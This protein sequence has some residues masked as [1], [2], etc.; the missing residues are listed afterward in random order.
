MSSMRFGCPVGRP[1]AFNEE[2]ALGKALEVFWCKGYDGASLT[3]LTEAMGINKPSLYAT[4]GNKEQLFLKALDLYEHR[5]CAYFSP[6]LEEP[7]ARQV[8]EHMLLGAA[9]SFTTKTG[10]RG[11]VVVQSALACSEAS[12]SVK[13]ALVARRREGENLLR[14]RL[15]RAKEE[16]DLPADADPALL[17]RYIGTV[18]QGMAVQAVNGATAEQLKEVALMTLNTWPTK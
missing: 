8:V 2:E 13:E 4:F 18:A 14:E 3:D 15:E 6:A 16:G 12:A 17:A 1:R 10:P 11:C 5:P 7:T 9:E